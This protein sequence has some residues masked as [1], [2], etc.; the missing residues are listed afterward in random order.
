M[1]NPAP[2]ITG[3]PFGPSLSKS[4]AVSPA[5]HLKQTLFKGRGNNS[6]RSGR[7]F[8][9]L[10]V[11]LGLFGLSLPADAATYSTITIPFNWI[12]PSAHAKLGPATGG[13][14]STLYK[15]TN[16]GGCGTTPPNIDDTLSDDIPLGFSFKYGG[17]PFT[18]VRV[19]ANG[20]LQFNNNITCGSGSPVTQIP[21]P[22]ASL[23][24]SLRIYGND[25][26]P[27]LKS[28]VSGYAT[29]CISRTS[30][31]VSY[32]TLGSAP[33]RSFV[34]TWSNVPEWTSAS[35][36]SGS[37]NL[38]VIL[39]ENGE[40]I[41]QFG[42]S[43]HGP[44]AKLAQI[45][46]QISTSD[47]AISAT[48]YPADNTA[49]K[50][51]IP[52]AV[53]TPSSFN[54]FESLTA[55]G[56]T[57]G[58][59]KTKIAGTTFNVDLVAL[60]STGTAVLTAFIGDVAV[61][62]VNATS[63]TC[64]SYP[65][66][67]STKVAT[68][69]ATD[70]GRKS[71]S[72]TENNAWKNVRLRLKYPTFSPTVITCSSDNFAIRP[73]RFSAS[74]TD[75]TWTTAGTT[76]TL[77]AGSATATPTHKAGQPFTLTATAYNSAGVATSGYSSSAPTVSLIG[78][79]LPTSGCTTGSLSGGTFTVTSGIATSTLASYS[80]IGAI[81]ASIDDASFAA[82]DAADGSSA[83]ERTISSGAFSIGR[84]VPNHFDVT[85]NAPKFSPACNRFSYIGQPFG[86][87]TAPM[88]TITA[89]N[90]AGTVTQNYAGGL[91][92][93]PGNGSTITGQSWSAASGTV[94]PIGS[95][96]A[97][98]VAS[99]G[100][101]V[102]TITFA[103][104]NPASGGGLSFSRTTAIT[105]FNASLSLAANIADSDGVSYA[106]NPFVLSGIGFDDGNAAT[107]TDAQM[108]YGRIRLSNAHG[109]E[110]TTL[111]VPMTAQYFNGTAF[112]AATD[113]QCS[114]A[115]VSLSDPIAAPTDS[116]T[117]ADSCIWDN[118]T[119]S[120][121]NRCATIGTAA[122]NYREAAG[123]TDGNFNLNLKATNKIGALDVTATVANWLKFD[124][125]GNGNQN[126]VAR[127]TFGIFKGD[128]KQIYLREV[129]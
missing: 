111:P 88:L 124:W 46:W 34:V 127:A 37:Y 107:A 110:L 70:L 62:L 115:T 67:G 93:M 5:T 18:S 98:T 39:Q 26:D 14:Y 27:T 71:V 57:T 44:A 108:R 92:N 126:P 49:I 30:C 25:L 23:N 104:G 20:R 2:V 114:V 59:I 43:I 84:F 10:L 109:S 21:Y 116:L 53:P 117:V 16:P 96:P 89:K 128:S 72:F 45:G 54:G 83:A 36:A 80:E 113:D 63:G 103:V 38:Q 9:L 69:A 35:A 122:D 29:S 55:G 65:T 1:M 50:F 24:Y 85:A 123:L 6:S 8:A 32:A 41:Y 48:G 95:L 15:F 77:N 119:L 52:V 112:V 61:E 100:A 73:A 68:F 99:S 66:I 75:T 102:G 13:V 22:N 118:D 81:S 58:A 60:N 91:W 40:F 7:L 105:P 28:E 17:T 74:A 121:G 12:D 51:F 11:L 82:V 31:F 129:Y 125:T 47:Y 76:R 64:S 3:I 94:S 120:G 56:A 33:N 101:G 97:P 78:C 90:S 79:I 4:D 106:G 86:F 87:G 19:M 42:P